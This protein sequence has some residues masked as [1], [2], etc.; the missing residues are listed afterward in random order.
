MPPY[1]EA[2][3]YQVKR[4]QYLSP[5]RHLSS[6]PVMPPPPPSSHTSLVTPPLSAAAAAAKHNDI[7]TLTGGLR[8]FWHSIHSVGVGEGEGGRRIKMMKRMWKKSGFERR[9]KMRRRRE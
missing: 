9:K 4:F 2:E 5:E 8:S 6:S 3:N 7:T 1:N